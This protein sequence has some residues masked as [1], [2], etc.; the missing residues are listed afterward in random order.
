MPLSWNE[1]KQRA[2]TLAD[3]YDPLTM[4]PELV[5]A[6]QALDRAVDLAYRPAPFPTDRA[7][8]EFLFARY[9]DLTTGPL[10]A[11]MKAKPKRTR[12]NKPNAC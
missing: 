10:E 2:S 9:A 1:I 12:L 5:K 8:V 3:L 11:G 4:P 6:H 7:R